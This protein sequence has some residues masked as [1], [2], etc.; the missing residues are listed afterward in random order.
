[1]NLPARPF[2]ATPTVPSSWHAHLALTIARTA[3]GSRL[4]RSEHTGPLYVQKPFYPEGA[5]CAHIYLLHPPGGLVS[6]DLLGIDI[7]VNEHAHA[8]VTTPG[9]GRVYRARDDGLLQ[10]QHTQLR[11]ADNAMLEWMPLETILF[12]KSKGQLRTR[13]DLGTDS[14]FIGWDILSLGLPANDIA[15]DTDCS[16][17][18]SLRIYRDGRLLLNER[19]VLREGN[20][21]LLTA[22]A[23][24]RHLPVQG[25]LVAGPFVSEDDKKAA[26]TLIT[27]LQ[28]VCEQNKSVVPL[29]GVTLNGEFIVVRCLGRCSSEARELLV[30][31]WTKIRPEVMQRPACAPRIWAT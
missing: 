15:L 25:V 30:K 31:A 24:F 4:T 28:Q 7:D 13:V 1:M 5:D 20:H 27:E 23:G 12:P 3:R 2:T 11:V 26:Q 17:D 8:L 29:S 6:G 16:L 22:A 18:Q 10:R 21:H 14:F 9:A 19:L